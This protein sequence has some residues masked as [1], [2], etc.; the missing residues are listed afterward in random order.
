MRRSRLFREDFWV[1]FFHVFLMQSQHIKKRRKVSLAVSKPSTASQRVR[2][3]TN[4]S[5][6]APIPNLW[7]DDLNDAPPIQSPL[8][9]LNIRNNSHL[10]LS[11]TISAASSLRGFSVGQPNPIQADTAKPKPSEAELHAALRDTFNQL[12]LS[13]EAC[14]LPSLSRCLGQ[15]KATATSLEKQNL[16]PSA[17]TTLWIRQGAISSLFY[18][19]DLVPAVVVSSQ[20]DVSSSPSIPPTQPPEENQSFEIKQPKLVIGTA[21]SMAVDVID[22]TLDADEEED[23]II[24]P[25][26][27]LPSNVVPPPI[28]LTSSQ[29][30]ISDSDPFEMPGT[31][32]LHPIYVPPVEVPAISSAKRIHGNAFDDAQQTSTTLDSESELHTPKRRSKE[33][34]TSVRAQPSAQAQRNSP[35]QAAPTLNTVAIGQPPLQQLPAVELSKEDEVKPSARIGIKPWMKSAPGQ[36]AGSTQ[37]GRMAVSA[38]VSTPEPDAVILSAAAEP[39]SAPLHLQQQPPNVSQ[40]PW[41]NYVRPQAPV[42]NVSHSTS[43]S[44]QKPIMRQES[45]TVHAVAQKPWMKPMPA[46]K[47]PTPVATVATGPAGPAPNGIKPWMRPAPARGN[48]QSNAVASMGSLTGGAKPWMRPSNPPQQSPPA[49]AVSCPACNQKMPL[50]SLP[51]VL[52]NDCISTFG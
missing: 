44:E 40:K 12:N 4:S 28:S 37:H 34:P 19:P 23:A 42:S 10:N 45:S 2:H 50:G 41:M 51:G 11:E 16:F 14:L 21:H 1:S 30:S 46:L 15:S 22:L 32:S 3:H 9:T 24:S 49:S 20:N 38:L 18:E 39:A 27:G 26:I 43:F 6:P 47:Q 5:S 8:K 36:T 48:L 17:E 7:P 35:Y 33:S 25:G 29:P 52:C 31:P 13:N